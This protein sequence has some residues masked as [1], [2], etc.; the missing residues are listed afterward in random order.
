M[1]NCCLVCPGVSKP[2]KWGGE[3]R[4][5][6]A[7]IWSPTK[8]HCHTTQCS[9]PSHDNSF[10]RLNNRSALGLLLMAPRSSPRRGIM[11]QAQAVLLCLGVVS[12]TTFTQAFVTPAPSPS[13][14]SAVSPL[15]A[16]R[17]FDGLFKGASSTVSS[18][19]SQRVQLGDLQVS[20]MGV[21]TWAWGNQFLWGYSPQ[22]S[23]AAL[24]ETF[25]HVLNAG[26][27]WFDSADSYGTG[28]LEGR[29]EVLLGQFLKEHD[30]KRGGGKVR[31]AEDVYVATKIAPYP[32]RLGKGSIKNAMK[33]SSRRLDRG[34]PGVDIG[35]LHWAPPLG[36]QEKA[37]WEGLAELKQE[38][39]IKA[40][41]LSNYG[42]KK[43][44]QAAETFRREHGVSLASNQVQFSLVSTLP[45][46]SGLV[47]TAASEGVR[48]IA[49]SPL[50][51]GI[52][53]GRYSMEKQQLPEGPRRILFKELLPALAPVLAIMGEIAAERTRKNQ[54]ARGQPVTYSQVALNWCRSKGAVP[55]VGLKCLKQAKEATAA[56][57]WKLS[58]AE[59]AALDAAVASM[60]KG[61]GQTVQN[62]FQT[63]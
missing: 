12:S 33:E 4:P 6:F 28:R 48:L 16:G 31:S 15:Y 39:N 56:L 1:R 35:Q 13:T 26:I 8:T 2:A 60:P 55:I 32:F 34:R 22:K 27:N 45:L 18:S 54:G 10:P 20:P 24:Q 3:S 19:S 51:L 38:G 36:W 63:E 49:Y 43:L 42:P 57:E 41:G 47:E 5:Q 23:D 52:L 62:I 21:G 17:L 25:D 14:H 29:S 61:K 50:G 9:E 7:S 44:R 37:Y 58:S 59:A 30:Y 53:T 40:I 46:Q 11:P